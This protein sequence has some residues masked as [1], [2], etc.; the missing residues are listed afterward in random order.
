MSKKTFVDA[1][2]ASDNSKFHIGDYKIHEDD[3]FLVGDSELKTHGFINHH[4]SAINDFYKNGI[5]QIIV[6]GFKAERDIINKRDKTPEDRS[7]EKIHVVVNFKNV[8]IG[9]PTSTNYFS[10]KPD[11][12]YPNMARLLGKTYSAP[13]SVSVEIKAT[14]YMKDGT[15]S[16]R[17]DKVDNFE[18]CRMPIM[19]RSSMC[20]TFN[21]SRQA[22]I[23]L[24]EDPDD[25]GGYF[26]IKGIEWSI[27]GIENNLFNSI[28]VYK[29]EGYGKE[30]FRSDFISIPGNANANQ[31]Y[32]VVRCLKDG[33]ITC[34][35]VKSNLREVEIPMYLLFRLL[36]CANDKEIYDNIIYDDANNISTPTG[37]K[38]FKYIEDAFN[39]KY[40]SVPDGQ[41]EYRPTKILEMLVDVLKVTEF[42]YLKLDENPEAY[43]QAMG[44]LQR[45][46]DINLFPHIGLTP[47]YR[48]IKFR[49]LGLIMRKIMLVRL[50]ILKPTDRDSFINKRLDIAGLAKPTKTGFNAA[51]IMKIRKRFSQDFKNN[52]FS[53]VNLA[54]SFKHS[55]YGADFERLLSQAI[56]SGNKAELSINRR[57]ITNRLSTQLLGRK[58]TLHTLSTL[59]QITTTTSESAKQSERA[60]EMRRVHMTFFGYVC[61]MSTSTGGKVGIN[62]QLAL[63]A[64]VSLASP[65]HLIRK[66]LTEDKDIILLD[67]V[68]P[69]QIERQSLSHVYVNGYW[70]GC[71]K[72]SIKL[73][74]KY[75]KMRREGKINNQTTIYWENTQDEVYF[76]VDRGRLMRPLLIVYNNRRDPEK[77]PIQDR[78]PSAKFKQ[79][80]AI[81]TEHIKMLNTGELD[82]KKMIDMQLVEYISLEEQTNL[83]LCPTFDYLEKDQNNELHEWTHCDIPQSQFGMT[84]LTVPFGNHDQSPRL[85]FQSNQGNQTAGYFSKNWPF[86][87]DKIAF[88]Q[89][90]CEMP[91]VRTVINRYVSSNGCNCMVAIMCNTGYNQEDSLIASRGASDRGLF[92]G[93][94]F[95]YYKTEL[96]QKEEFSNPDVNVTTDIK[97]SNYEKLENGIIAIGTIVHK[98]DAIIGKVAKITKTAGKYLFID[99]SIVYKDTEEAIVHNVIRG[100]NEDDEKFCKVVLR[101]RRPVAIGD[102]FSSRHGQKGICALL[103]RDSDMPRTADG[104]AP[105]LIINPHAFPSRMTIGQMIEM[106]ASNYCA[107]KGVYIDAT[108]FKKVDVE[109]IGDELEAMGESRHGFYKLY[110]GITGEWIDSEIFMGGTFY[111]RLQKFVIDQIRSVTSGGSD[112]L[113]YQPLDGRAN[114]GG[115]RIGEMEQWCLSAAGVARFQS[116]K[117]RDHSD[118]Y[119]QYICRCGR[120]A[121]YNEQKKL[122]K[123]KHCGDNLDVCEVP[124]TWTSKL[125]VHELESMG[126][127][128]K[129]YPKPYTFPVYEDTK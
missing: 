36:G 44:I 43:Q 25:P 112:A 11:I 12:L 84:V 115:L 98:N 74:K 14:A 123:C 56:I 42:S 99:R 41:Y 91:L 104:M 117:F 120:A 49:F 82:I 39:I 71:V 63:F 75:R 29:N 119:T 102:K 124:T 52:T 60:N 24:N 68:D 96:D 3:L 20:N 65:L 69:Q 33:Q 4:I 94:K 54:N 127:G 53:S 58:N 16:T 17:K 108:I 37:V 76:W 116:E 32:F 128:I 21:C 38:M 46:L 105:S 81:T 72:D 89:Y 129:R 19:V 34:Q 2:S 35:V 101:K 28:R 57:R 22:L 47:E 87:C 73:V 106:V 77:F 114:G 85:S 64:S 50:G 107:R 70:L 30:I 8:K 23:D 122:Y 111:Q 51:V 45:E 13:C 61:I 7:I 26:L 125:L 100:R 31:G 18:I 66:M 55:I 88:L 80:L 95:T 126:I 5:E 9:K 121:V 90:K 10:G 62:K 59:R 1:K 110:N 27:D 93:C 103:M 97:S 15:Q 67:D 92:N 109:S 78:K 83:V 40:S 86:R 118:G 48:K 113:T 79:G 6:H